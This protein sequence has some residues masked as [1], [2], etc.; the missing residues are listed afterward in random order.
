MRDKH[1]YKSGVQDK[2]SAATNVGPLDWIRT[3]TIYCL[4]IPEPYCC[5][6]RVSR[7]SDQDLLEPRAKERV[8]HAESSTHRERCLSSQTLMVE[9]LSIVMVAGQG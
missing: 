6:E 7:S 9:T 5:F 2:S 3:D 1:S 8:L 4:C